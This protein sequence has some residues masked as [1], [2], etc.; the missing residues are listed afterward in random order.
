MFAT[1]IRLLARGPRRSSQ[2]PKSRSALVGKKPMDPKVPPQ[3]AYRLADILHSILNEHGPLTVA[4][5]WSHAEAAGFKSKAHMKVLLRWMKERHRVRLVGHYKEKKVDEEDS[6]RYATLF[7]NKA[8]ESP[9]DKDG[10]EEENS[11]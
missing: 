11:A 3:E 1:A 9:L 4:G 7:Y 10:T 6:M 5:C 8:K 2:V